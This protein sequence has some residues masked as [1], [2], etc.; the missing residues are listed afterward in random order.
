MR[1]GKCD[2]RQLEQL[3][4]KL[5]QLAEIDFDRFCR[6]A[7][8]ELA[9]RLLAKVKKRTPVVYGTLRDAWAVMPV[10]HRGTHYTVVVLNHLQYASYV[11]YGHRQ[12]PGRFIPGYWKGGRFLYDPTAEG[13]MV[14]KKSWVQGRYM[15]TISSQELEGQ[16]P[17]LLEKK[18]YR[19]LK[20]CFDVR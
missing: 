6:Q 4:Q 8:A 19:F 16:L 12:Q 7:A 20:G 2:F 15:L 14:L 11:E 17:A 1:W 5:E 3:N 10:G 13:G 9:E 18:L